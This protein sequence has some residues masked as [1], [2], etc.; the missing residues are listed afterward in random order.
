MKNLNIALLGLPGAGKGL[1]S[2]ILVNE[3]NFFHL[4]IGKL[5]RDNIKEQTALGNQIKKYVDNGNLVPDAVVLDVINNYIKNNLNEK[6]IILD[7]FPRNKSQAE[8]LDEALSRYGTELHML[9]IIEV[10]KNEV[11]NRIK[12]RL[13]TTNRVDDQ[14]NDK[15]L[16]R[17]NSYYKEA[18]GVIEYYQS[19]EKLFR[20]SGVGSKEMVFNRLKELIDKF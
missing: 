19:K 7:G 4:S 14:S 10:P 13:T 20:I 6:G 18:P 15:V 12:Y 1:Q 16:N 17:I 8:A 9:I 11:I 5:F 3:Y 2:K